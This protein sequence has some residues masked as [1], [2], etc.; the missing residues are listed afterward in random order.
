MEAPAEADASP[1]TPQEAQM[2]AAGPEDATEAGD[3][4]AAF[5]VEEPQLTPMPP[6]ASRGL[7]G[8]AAAMAELPLAAL[9][10]ALA[11]A[12]V[13]A[14]A[15]LPAGAGFAFADGQTLSV[16]DG[17]SG[18]RKVATAPGIQMPIV[19]DARDRI[20]YRVQEEDGLEIWTTSWDGKNPS[21]L[22]SEGD[23][24]GESIGGQRIQSVEWI[25]GQ[26][27]LA[28]VTAAVAAA[29]ELTPRLEL[30][31]ADAVSGESRRVLEMGPTGRVFYAPDGNRFAVLEYG[32]REQPEG[33]LT[34]YGADGG[35]GRTVARF[36][37][38][39]GASSYPTQVQWLPSG[40][41]L[42]FAAPAQEGGIALYLVGASGE[43]QLLGDVPAYEAAWSADGSQLAYSQP[44]EGS[45]VL[46]SLVLAGQDGSDPQPYAQWQSGEFLGWSPNGEEFLYTA[47]N[48]VYIGAPGREPMLLGNSVSVHDPYWVAPEQVVSLL[49]QGA[50]W[51]LVWRNV[52][53]G[54]AGSLAPLPKDISYDFESPTAP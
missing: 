30:W 9:T 39:P 8:A 3:A 51:M 54:D 37:A 36:P 27:R 38:A 12:M 35:E 10:P 31:R 50:G 33:S 18:L 47:D 6:P 28:L 16:L 17:A 32:T 19:S 5:A 53:N 4:A 42:L 25:P 24:A 15:V 14:D 23:L 1:A 43:A 40:D 7:D 26:A 13:S 46:G 48:Q 49:D 41:G 45:P 34:V 44:V 2:K 52:S 29:G 11:P 21:R 20:A 22:L